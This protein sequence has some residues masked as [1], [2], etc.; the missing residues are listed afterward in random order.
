M[1]SPLSERVARAQPPSWR[2]AL[3]DFAV[4]RLILLAASVQIIEVGCAALITH[5]LHAKVRDLFSMPC[6]VLLPFI[7]PAILASFVVYSLCVRLIERRPLSELNLAPAPCYLALGA[8]GGSLLFGTIYGTIWAQGYAKYGGYAGLADIPTAALIFAVGAAFEE[9]IFRGA[10]F[11][12]V[13]ECLGT[14]LA[15]GFSAL[16]FGLSHLGNNGATMISVLSVAV[17]GG[18]TMGLT[19]VLTK[20]LWL[21]MGVHFGWNFTQGAVFGAAVS[22]YN[23]QCA[24]KFDL[25]GP[26]LVTGGV[27]GPEASIYAIV[28]GVI[29]AVGLGTLAYR[30]QQWVPLHFQR[31]MEMPRVDPR[32][33]RN[34]AA[35]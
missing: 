5:F 35:Q 17:T 29:S 4:V 12:V 21:P 6:L 18:I 24:F 8:S 20:S 11:R 33:K 30:S 26:A 22:G 32:I 9:L 15:L 3:F 2:A 28:F 31:S 10:I 34:G 7:V 1:K 19:Y 25:S 16:I 13:E 23:L 27:F 14:S